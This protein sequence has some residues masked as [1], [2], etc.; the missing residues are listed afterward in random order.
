MELNEFNQPIGAPVSSPRGTAGYAWDT[1]A[2][3]G[4]IRSIQ[5]GDFSFNKGSGGTIS[6][7]GAANGNGLMNV[8]N[9][10]G[11]T[12]VTADNNG[13]TIN[14]GSITIKNSSGSAVIDSMGLNS[15][16][17][18]KGT[19]VAAFDLTYTTTSTTPVNITSA[20]LG[21]NLA[22][23]S[24]LLVYYFGDIDNSNFLNSNGSH[25]VILTL[26]DTEVGNN[27]FSLYS[28]GESW[29]NSSGTAVTTGIRSN[30]IAMV[31]IV[32]F[33]AGT[34]TL[35]EQIQCENGGTAEL[36]GWEMGYL[37]LGN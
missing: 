31:R 18:F 2:D 19:A 36:Y 29:A 32:Q 16:N 14:N 26:K 28:G 35:V 23:D 20:S 5:L 12:V 33:S 4:M 9:S 24:Y 27:V 6:L 8:L 10:S 7:G 11:G 37:I 17:N 22:R 34:H 15:L 1:T 25:R 30:N 21:F 13:L 3:R